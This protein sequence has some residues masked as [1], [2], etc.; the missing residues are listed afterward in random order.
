LKSLDFFYFTT[1]AD[2]W[3]MAWLGFGLTGGGVIAYLLIF[4]WDADTPLKKTIAIAM[5]VVCV[6]GEVA[7][8]G[9]GLWIDTWQTGGWQLTETDFRFMVTVIQ[10]LGFIHAFALIGYVA[11]DQLAEVFGDEDGDGV[12]NALDND[13]KK[14]RPATMQPSRQYGADE[15]FTDRQSR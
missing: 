4:M 10:L 6:L 9:F 13:Y 3:Y 2:Q 12:I 5:L 11:G 8:A 14:K 15:D 1:P 7:T